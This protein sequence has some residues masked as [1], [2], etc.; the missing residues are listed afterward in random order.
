MI[1]SKM[2]GKNGPAGK[3]VDAMDPKTVKELETMKK[4]N[5]HLLQ[6]LFEFEQENKSLE[7]CFIELDA[8]IKNVNVT[9]ASMAKNKSKETVIKC[10]SLEKLLSVGIYFIQVFQIMWLI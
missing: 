9:N 5:E 7:A 6:I 10:P 1:E 4:R 8:K 3:Q 2:A